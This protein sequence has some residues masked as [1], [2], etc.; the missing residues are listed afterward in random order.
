MKKQATIYNYNEIAIDSTFS[1]TRTVTKKDVSAFA[2]LS[3]DFNPLHVDDNFGKNSKFGKN[4]VH[5][6][7]TASLLSTLVG[8]YCPGERCL[9]LGQTLQFKM[10]LFYDETVDVKGTVISKVNAFKMLKIKTEI[11]RGKDLILTGEAQVQ[12]LG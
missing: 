4:V 5:G 3:G 7:L 9:Y 6:M 1:F 8:M 12:L 11:Y 10:P 2:T